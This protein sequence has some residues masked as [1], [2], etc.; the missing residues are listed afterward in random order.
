MYYGTNNYDFRAVPTQD[1]QSPPLVGALAKATHRENSFCAQAQK[2]YQMIA[3]LCGAYVVMYNNRKHITV[4][5]Y[6]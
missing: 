4:G 5:I 1:E 2:S 3:P 6:A